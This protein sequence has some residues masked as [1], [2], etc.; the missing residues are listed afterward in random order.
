MFVDA[1]REGKQIICTTHSSFLILALNRPIAKGEFKADDVAVYD[2]SKDEEGTHVA[3]LSLT[4][5]GYISGWIP[6]FRQVEQELLDEWMQTL[7]EA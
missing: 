4:T 5:Q 6:S 2:V 7:P 1:I 3:P